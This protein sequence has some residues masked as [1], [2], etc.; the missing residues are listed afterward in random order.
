MMSR[1][2]YDATEEGFWHNRQME[3]DGWTRE[4]LIAQ[5]MYMGDDDGNHDEH[6]QSAAGGIRAAAPGHGALPR[7]E[8][9]N[10]VLGDGEQPE[11]TGQSQVRDTDRRAQ[12]GQIAL[13]L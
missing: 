8:Q 7:D 9:P 3:M 10:G 1:A 2:E 4:N 13:P 11:R 5:G 6:G 12:A